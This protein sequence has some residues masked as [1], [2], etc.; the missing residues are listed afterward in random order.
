MCAA[1]RKTAAK[2]GRVSKRV[3]KKQKSNA[4]AV[5]LQEP[6]PDP[7]IGMLQEQREIKEAES[8][9]PHPG[10]TI[11]R[12]IQALELRTVKAGSGGLGRLAVA[13]NEAARRGQVVGMFLE[14]GNYVICLDRSV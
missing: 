7:E 12:R 10:P 4:A 2:P 11:E 6:L 13:V 1:K 3:S 14:G 9:M 5:R 8:V